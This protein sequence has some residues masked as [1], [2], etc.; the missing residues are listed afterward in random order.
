MDS[1]V[2]L[3][4]LLSI[5]LALY[6]GYLYSLDMFYGGLGMFLVLFLRWLFLDKIDAVLLPLHIKE[7]HDR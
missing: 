1:N 7:S 6:V 2:F 5:G 3:S 4:G